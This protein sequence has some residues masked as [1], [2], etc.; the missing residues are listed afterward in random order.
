MVVPF[1]KTKKTGKDLRRTD[2]LNSISLGTKNGP[3]RPKLKIYLDVAAQR[4]NQS[5]DFLREI[6]R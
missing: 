5:T 3:V 6:V 1:I 4:D 2:L